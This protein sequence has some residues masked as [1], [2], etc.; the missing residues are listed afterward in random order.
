M[1]DLIQVLG[2]VGLIIAGLCYILV[3]YYD[4]TEKGR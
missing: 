1:L 2:I 3:M 4:L